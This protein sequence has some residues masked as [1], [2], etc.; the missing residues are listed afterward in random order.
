M[1]DDPAPVSG[2]E[3]GVK[4]LMLDPIRRVLRG[5]MPWIQFQE[6]RREGFV[7]AWRRARLQRP[8]LQTPPVR[9][10]ATGPVEIRVLTWR[11]DWVNLIWALKTFYHHAGVE[12]PLVIHDGGLLPKQVPLLLAHF[13]DARY[14]SMADADTRFPAELRRRGLAR[15]AEYRGK[16]VS[17]RKLFDFYLDSTADYVLTIDSDIVFFRRPEELIAR[18]GGW[19][20]NLY[21][22]DLDY[23][24]SMPLDELEAAFGV[25][26]PPCVNSGLAL[27]RRESIDLPV[28]ERYLEHPKLFADPWVTE[29]TLHALCSVT[30][31]LEFLPDSYRVG[32]PP[33]LT[34]DLVCKHYPG[35]FRPLLYTEGMRHLLATGLIAALD[36]SDSRVA[37]LPDR[38][39]N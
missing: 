12:Y 10:A 38:A 31:G 34:P 26:P 20:R 3:Q 1:G 17:T 23:W 2:G 5:W 27:V 36:R 6:L 13:P 35:T 25:R 32:G 39:V 14:I 15:S 4:Y 8:I 18:P 19:P 28:V 30:H 7:A 24:Y 9:T 33:G 16:N 37:P 11:R 22:R 29:Q 21:N